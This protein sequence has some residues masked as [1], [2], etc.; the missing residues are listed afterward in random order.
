MEMRYC[1]TFAGCHR[2][3]HRTACAKPEQDK[4]FGRTS[5]QPLE[6]NELL[7]DKVRSAEEIAR[8]SLALFG[9]V[10]LALD[11]PRLEII[12]WL[13]DEGLWDELTPWEL[14][15][16]SAEKPAE[17]QTVIAS[18][19]SEALVV[20]LWALRKV[21]T[22]PAPN[23]QCDTSLFQE[24][25]PP[26]ADMPAAQFIAFAERR[27]DDA[28]HE[29]AYEVMHLHWQAR[30]AQIHSKPVPHVDIEIIQERHHAINWVIGYDALPW[31]EVTTDT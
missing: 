24:L 26:F 30:D 27:S 11:A 21:E 17:R 2:R 25:L 5:S 3:T 29:M 22:L 19:M 8:R 31:D 15:Y 20:L 23:E 18:W 14:A 10:G 16:V 13:R 28:L 6:M 4:R 12:S 9:V 7:P 1:E